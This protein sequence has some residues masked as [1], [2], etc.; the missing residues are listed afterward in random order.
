MT[1][2]QIEEFKARILNPNS[3]IDFDKQTIILDENNICQMYHLWIL[4]K[5]IR[6]FVISRKTNQARQELI[7]KYNIELANSYIQIVDIDQ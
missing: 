4:Q 1:F 2:D 3:Q 6:P 5:Q 7:Q